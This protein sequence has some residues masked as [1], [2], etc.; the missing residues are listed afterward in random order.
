MNPAANDAANKPMADSVAPGAPAA[1]VNGAASGGIAPATAVG[2]GTP[3]DAPGSPPE[4]SGTGVE[5][6]ARSTAHPDHGTIDMTADQLK[7][8]PAFRFAD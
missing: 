4:M 2:L 5:T 1:A 8:A 7:S 6:A 3:T